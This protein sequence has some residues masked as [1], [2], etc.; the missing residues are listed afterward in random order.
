MMAPEPRQ[1]SISANITSTPTESPIRAVATDY[2]NRLA[3]VDPQAAQALGQAVDSQLP[4]V[5]PDD[6]DARRKIGDQA[7]SALS[8]AI[9]ESRYPVAA[10][11]DLAA[12]L[13]ERLAADAVLDD[14]GF[15][16][17]LLAPLA[18]PVQQI[19]EV[20]EAMPLRNESDAVA[21]AAELRRGPSALAGYRQT[22]RRAAGG[23]HRV[24]ARQ[25]EA[26]ARQC[27]DWCDPTGSDFFAGLS[28]AAG[29]I[30]RVS[31]S[32]AKAV[33]DA[34][35]LTAAAFSEFADFL[36]T[37]LLPDAPVT[38][39]AGRQLYA[40]TARAFLGA[41][42]DLD[43]TVAWGWDE[44]TRIGR[45]IKIAAEAIHPDGLGAAAA[46]LDA[47]PHRIVAG[48]TDIE[49]WLTDTVGEIA[50]FVDGNVVD[51]PP[52]ARLP[53]C[54]VS[55][56]GAG[57]MYYDPPDPGLIRPGTIWWA[58]EATQI[59]HTWR[60]RTTLLHEGIPGH[61]LQISSALTAPD[62]H[63]W[64]RAL[65]HIHGYAEGWAHHSEAWSAEIGLLD[66]P[67]DRLGMLIGQAWRAARIVIDAGLHLDLP[68]PAGRGIDAER[69]TY[70]TAV[71]YLRRI[72][73]LGE[74]MAGFE[75]DRYLGWPAQALSFRVGA[76]LFSEI[77]DQ[78]RA[79]PGY[80]QR[81][82]H[83]ELLRRGPMGLAPLRERVAQMPTLTSG[84][85]A[86]HG[87]G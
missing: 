50:D 48:P 61:H 28:R 17:R 73:G 27:R 36:T 77:V 72:T 69:W 18:T 39:G 76:R 65:C 47:D 9:T 81:T 64:Q 14:S 56:S 33:D 54:L 45:E 21:L 55:R 84:R 85:A 11:L 24:A 44:L 49:A 20:F 79:R 25:V 71:A 63:P 4:R 1:T 5:A 7:F 38:D 60:E 13:G 87:G 22:L 86:P 29:S 8:R 58:T 15:T 40:V 75:V 3:Q 16:Q 34:V 32:T 68:I 83:T 37:D 41:E 70:P 6:F 46:M 26:V 62:L 52:S 19:R 78:A 67:A 51:L 66:D 10:D 30:P 59:V 42:V 31:S 82:F 43:E 74:R 23:G 53:R 80:V 2:V 57:V 35:R 12:A